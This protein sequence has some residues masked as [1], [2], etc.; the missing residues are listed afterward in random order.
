MEIDI[1]ITK[2]GGVHDVR[3]VT[4]IGERIYSE[5]TAVMP[6]SKQPDPAGLELEILESVKRH[7]IAIQEKILKEV[8]DGSQSESKTDI[9]S[10]PS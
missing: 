2:F 6:A 10:G 5:S 3:T 9:G 8:K 7:V 4:T 1:I